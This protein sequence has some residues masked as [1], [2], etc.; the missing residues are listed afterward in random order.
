MGVLQVSKD[1]KTDGYPLSAI[2]ILVQFWLDDRSGVAG[3]VERE[4]ARNRNEIHR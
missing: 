4:W 3:D 2:E 1:R